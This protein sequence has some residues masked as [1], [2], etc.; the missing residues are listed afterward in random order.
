MTAREY[1][2][3]VGFKLEYFE[4]VNL[5]LTEKGPEKSVSYFDLMEEYHIAK[6]KEEAKEVKK[7][8]KVCISEDELKALNKVLKVIDASKGEN[9]KTIA[10]L[11]NLYSK[12]TLQYQSQP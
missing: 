1:M 2:E 4:H 11:I 10:H 12:L 7:Q 5:L 9:S 3:K 8:L 6:S